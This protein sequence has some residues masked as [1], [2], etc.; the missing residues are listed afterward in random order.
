MKEKQT[1]RFLPF[2]I[3]SNL[4][5]ANFIYLLLWERISPRAL[6]ACCCWDG[7]SFW[8]WIDSTSSLTSSIS[9]SSSHWS[10]LL[11]AF[12][13]SR[14][15]TCEERFPLLCCSINAK[16]LTSKP[17]FYT[18]TT[19]GKKSALFE[20]NKGTCQTQPT[21]LLRNTQ[22]GCQSWRCRDWNPVSRDPLNVV[23]WLLC[24]QLGP[25]W[26]HVHLSFLLFSFISFFMTML[27][28]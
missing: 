23:M 10:W 25:S 26:L 15:S 12:A 5:H 9:F 6:K 11:P 13:F 2:Q 3:N 16:V 7:S 18:Q 21:C 28:Q 24:V 17:N 8:Y 1:S 14:F 22:D 27:L 4:Q 20:D 19:V